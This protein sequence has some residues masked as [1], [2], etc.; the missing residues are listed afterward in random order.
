MTGQVIS[1]NI[2]AAEGAQVLELPVA[3]LITDQ[4]LDGDR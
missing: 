4:G 2:A 3:T 1:I